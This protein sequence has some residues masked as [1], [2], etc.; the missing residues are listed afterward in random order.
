MADTV[1]QYIANQREHH[2]KSSF[3]EE[4]LSMLQKHNI[5]FDMRYVFESEIVG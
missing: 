3:K 2:R 1:K 5:E 4:Y